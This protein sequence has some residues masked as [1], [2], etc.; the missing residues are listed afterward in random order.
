MSVIDS[1]SP[2]EGWTTGGTVLEITGNKLDG[3]SVSVTV[4][5]VPCVIEKEQDH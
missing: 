5:G 1:V 4:D 3:S 2:N